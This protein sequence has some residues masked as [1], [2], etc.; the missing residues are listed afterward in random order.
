MLKARDHMKPGDL[1]VVTDGLNNVDKMYDHLGN[2]VKIMGLDQ[3]PCWPHGWA[4]ANQRL[5]GGDT[6]EQLWYFGRVIWTLPGDDILTVKRPY[7]P[8]VIKL[9]DFEGK[10]A[11]FGRGGIERHGEGNYDGTFTPRQA[12]NNTSGCVRNWNEVIVWWAKL[13]ESM[14][15]KGLR[16]WNTVDQ[17]GGAGQ[18]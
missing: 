4:G 7:G 2:R 12:L 9:V 6:P 17:P 3:V 5:R 8:A 15:K 11:A 13:T 14:A 18:V 1:H 16:I 10:E